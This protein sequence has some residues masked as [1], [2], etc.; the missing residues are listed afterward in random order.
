MKRATLS[1]AI[2]ALTVCVTSVLTWSTSH[3]IPPY[4]N[5]WQST[6]PDSLTDDNLDVGSGSACQVCHASSSGGQ[7]W[8]AYGWAIRERVEGGMTILEALAAV[9]PLNSDADPGSCSNID[10]IDGNTQP[11]WTP[12]SNNTFYFGDGTPMPDQPPPPDASVNGLDLMDPCCPE[13]LGGDGSVG[14]TDLLDLLAAWGTDPGGPP[15][16]DGDGD[17]STTDLLQLLAAWGTC[18]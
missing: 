17:V 3:A 4:L 7:P 12:G 15:D 14:T 2:G 16:F 10:E 9:E 11:G 18:P 6:Y 13:D 8:N 1:P 5:D